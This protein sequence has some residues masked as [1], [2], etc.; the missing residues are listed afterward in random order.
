M[1]FGSTKQLL[2][3]SLAAVFLLISGAA[4]AGETESILAR[5]G[6][7]Y[8]EWFKEN[9]A[10]KPAADQPAYPNKGGE[11]GLAASWRCKEC[12]GWDY[13]G[14]DGAYGKG[15]HMTGIIGITGAVGKDPATIAALLRAE[16]HGYTESQLPQ[17]DAEAL[18]LFVSKGQVDM[19]KYID[20][21]SGKPIGDGAKGEVYY[22]TI[23]AGCH[24]VDGKKVK[25]VALG[26]FDNPPEAVHKILNGQAG[27]AMPALRALDH[28]VTADIVA[29]IVNVLPE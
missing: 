2:T 24:G 25:D 1:R 23:C 29:Y 13:K 8:D 16:P 3:G 26:K 6:R 11:Y 19:D 27:E 20:P 5:G 14:K 28:Q 10:E 21:A 4:I 12:H 22:N 17:S 7:L 15:K 9:K 18:A